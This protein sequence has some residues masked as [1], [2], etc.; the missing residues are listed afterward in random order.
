[1]VK[2][3]SKL[4]K[5]IIMWG[6]FQLFKESPMGLIRE[7][8]DVVKKTFD[9]LEVNFTSW[10]SGNGVELDDI[11]KLEHDAD[12]LKGR[13]NLI[14]TTS[15]MSSMRKEDILSLIQ[16][17]D[18]IADAAEDVIKFLDFKNFKPGE[19]DMATL[20]SILSTSRQALDHYDS[21]LLEFIRFQKANRAPRYKRSI[22]DEI[23][24]IARCEK[25]VDEL[26]HQFG[27][28][29]FNAEDR[30]SP[31]EIMFLSKLVTIMNRITDSL[32]NGADRIK[33]MIAK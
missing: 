17:Q 4:L 9:T 22:P 23:K 31:V 1:M 12:R 18:S 7:H 20:D 10:K 11:D 8:F 28:L 16:I 21:L 2:Y 29:I 26:Q 6:F 13:V 14:V 27:K 3:F 25:V 32:E 19:Q 5:R 15:L 30:L 33:R 24:K